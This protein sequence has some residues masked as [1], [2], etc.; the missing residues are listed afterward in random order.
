MRGG[1]SL[2]ACMP[3]VALILAGPTAFAQTVTNTLT[4]SGSVVDDSGAPVS[5]AVVHYNNS[6]AVAT[7]AYG[8]TRPTAPLVSSHVVSGSNGAFSIPGLSPGNY[9]LCASGVTA[10]QLRSCDW[11]KPT[12]NVSL[13][14]G[15]AVQSVALTVTNGV[16]LTFLVSDPNGHIQ[17]FAAT[18]L[19]N[20]KLAPAGNFRI[21]VVDQQRYMDAKLTSV[22][23]SIHTYSLA[24]PKNRT[25]NLFL[26]TLLLASNSLSNAIPTRVQTNPISLGAAALSVSFNVQ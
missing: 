2:F 6:P 20:G 17:D 25:L 7:D 23:G 8:H 24:V 12:T 11:G 13:Q 3:I 21:F 9:L 14:T 15:G 19:V 26:D 1:G 16:L 22:A 4:I 5:G 18:P 10:T